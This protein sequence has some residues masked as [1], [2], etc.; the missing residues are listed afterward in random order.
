M[1]RVRGLE[2]PR[3]SSQ[4]PK[5]CA[6]TSSATPAQRTKHKLSYTKY[7]TIKQAIIY[8]FC[9]IYFIC[10]VLV[11]FLVVYGFWECVLQF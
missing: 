5:P 8:L 9:G 7:A 2:P 1:V 3:V 10:R 11:F 6:S 4:E